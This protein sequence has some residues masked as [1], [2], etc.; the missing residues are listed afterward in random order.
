MNDNELQKRLVYSK[1]RPSK[2]DDLRWI[3]NVIAE[4]YFD[5]NMLTNKEFDNL[6]ES[7]K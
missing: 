1:V 5:F 7:L 2:S 3:K 6:M 4:I